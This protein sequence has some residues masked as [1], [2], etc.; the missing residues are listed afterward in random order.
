LLQIPDLPPAI[1]A[2]FHVALVVRVD[3][4]Y[5]R[6]RRNSKPLNLL[7]DRFELQDSTAFVRFHEKEIL[8]RLHV[9]SYSYELVVVQR[10]LHPVTGVEVEGFC[11]WRGRRILLDAGLDSQQRRHTLRHEYF[12]AV[13]FRMG[14]PRGEDAADFAATVAD[15]L[16]HQLDALGGWAAVDRLFEPA[17]IEPMSL[18][19]A[20]HAI[21]QTRLKSPGAIT[22]SRFECKRCGAPTMVGDVTSS[23][24]RFDRELRRWTMDRTFDCHACDCVNRWTEYATDTGL[25]TGEQVPDRARMPAKHQAKIASVSGAEIASEMMPP[26]W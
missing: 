11:D 25:P 9:G 21:Q 13:A 23:P 19:S 6:R 5:R 17:R 2:R 22:I 14:N 24:A 3:G 18:V 10:L 1:S 12:H 15:D 4:L 8:M 26:P 20:I 7:G 16:D